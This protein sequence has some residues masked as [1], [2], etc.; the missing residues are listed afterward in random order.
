M[1]AALS[2]FRM[3]KLDDK[4]SINVFPENIAHASKESRQKYFDDAFGKFIDKFL[5][6]KV[7][8]ECQDGEDYVKNHGLCVIFLSMLVRQM[9]DTA[10]D[11]GGNRNLI[12]QKLLL[13]V[14]N[15]MGAFT[16]NVREMFIGIAQI[17]CML[18]PRLTEEFKWVFFVN[19]GEAQEGMLRMI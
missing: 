9:K 10:A 3:Q 19:W 5:L 14:F 17:E 4:I 1:V 16:K 11:A 12:N 7:N 6:Q 18:T 15:S 8:E 13:T 2:F